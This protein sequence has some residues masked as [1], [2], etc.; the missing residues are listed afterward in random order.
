M[1]NCGIVN[2]QILIRGGRVIDPAS[3]FDQTA[4]VLIRDGVVCEINTDSGGLKAASRDRTVRTID[5]EGCIVS[6]G[7]VDIHVHLREPSGVHR[8]TIATGAASAINGGFTTVCCMPN[9]NP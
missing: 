6:P 9:T 4:D 7:L 5:A 1:V 8:E 2:E 3:G